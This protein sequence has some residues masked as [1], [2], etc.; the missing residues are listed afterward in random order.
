MFCKHV[1][2]RNI[3]GIETKAEKLYIESCKLVYEW[4]NWGLHTEHA[5][6]IQYHINSIV[7]MEIDEYNPAIRIVVCNYDSDD[8]DTIF[9]KSVALYAGQR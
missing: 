6:D 3:D 5:S 7:Q 2:R 9:D 8:V 1:I 4:C